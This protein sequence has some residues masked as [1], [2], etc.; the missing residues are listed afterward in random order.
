MKSIFA[1]EIDSRGLTPI[2]AS[3]NLRELEDICEHVGLLH[4]GGV[5]FERDLEEMKLGIHKVQIVLPE[6]N[7]AENIDSLAPIN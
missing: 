5:V 2:I 6:E 4:R 1:E 7:E 3:H